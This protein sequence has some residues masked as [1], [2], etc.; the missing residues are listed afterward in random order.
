MRGLRTPVAIE[1]SPIA[2]RF[3]EINQ[4][5]EVMT[6]SVTPSGRPEIED[7]VAQDGSDPF[8]W[9]VIKQKKLLEAGCADPTDSKPTRV[10][11]ILEGAVF[12]HSPFRRLPWS[13][14]TYQ[15]LRM[16]L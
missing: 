16:A 7:D 10:G 15:P 13:R 2:K 9:L 4:E 5:F 6:M 8:G 14:Y 12:H 3:F 11:R 1:D